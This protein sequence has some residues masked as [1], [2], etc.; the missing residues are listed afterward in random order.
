MRI[1]IVECD[2]PWGHLRDRHGSFAD[3]F[4]HWMAPALPHARWHGLALHAG[5]P[6]PRPGDFDGYMITGSRHGVHDDAPW[7]APLAGFLRDLRARRIPVGGICFGHQIMA[8]AFG[9]RVEKSPSGWV[10]GP[11]AYDG[12]SA[13][14]MHQD[15]VLAAPEGAT[16]ITGSPRCLIGRI[17]YDFPA[18]SV[19]HHPEFS[20][21]F[22]QALLDEFG[23]TV[24]DQDQA[25]AAALQ[26]DTPLDTD[27]IAAEF[28]QVLT[29]R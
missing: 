10:L 14:A 3:M 18:L 7:I 13:Y 23:G 25:D 21:D 5:A 11:E 8:H 6:L 1:C 29:S 2:A 27:R 12:I 28:A 26:L 20:R 22:M 19:Q 24:I 15:Q 9:A 16:R 17:E 4:T